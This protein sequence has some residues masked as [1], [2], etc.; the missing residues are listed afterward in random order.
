[1]D[2]RFKRDLIKQKATASIKPIA[3][4]NMLELLR[5]KTKALKECNDK[6]SQYEIIGFIMALKTCMGWYDI[7]QKE[8][9]RITQY[10]NS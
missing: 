10:I 2:I 6:L 5:S 9:K 7:T 4:T 8:R 3:N 1:M